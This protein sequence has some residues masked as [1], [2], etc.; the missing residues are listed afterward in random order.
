MKREGKGKRGSSSIVCYGALNGLGCERIRWS[1]KDFEASVL[2]FVREL[3]L[4]SI[5]GDDDSKLAVL[6]NEI[7]ALTGQLGEV[8]ARMEKTYDLLDAG[9]A[10]EFVA[11]KLSELDARRV[12]VEHA[13]REKTGALDELRSEQRGFDDVK[14]LI[15]QLRGASDEV[16]RT[17]SIIASR[18]RSLVETILVA[19]QGHAPLDQ[20]AIE[21]ARQHGDQAVVDH[22]ERMT[23]R[24]RYFIVVFK[25][26][27][28]RAVYPSDHDPMQFEEQVTSSTAEGLIR[29][30]PA[31][32]EVVFPPRVT[33]IDPTTPSIP[34]P[35]QSSIDSK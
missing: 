2:S 22:L 29:H 33:A 4:A 26:G 35:P 5:M 28:M 17:R 9:S 16:Y 10:T 19:P 23:A 13:I 20:R 14:P 34:M 27:S 6:E 11:K 32:S 8:R 3:D 30:T 31:A 15:E 21:L 24:R 12:E 7:A 1:Y 25:D 18:L